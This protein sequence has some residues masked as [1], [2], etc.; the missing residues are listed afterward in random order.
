M[1]EVTFRMWTN[2]TM[3]TVHGSN[4]EEVISRFK[5]TVDELEIQGSGYDIISVIKT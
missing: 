1:Y 4:N 5:A 2:G 3:I